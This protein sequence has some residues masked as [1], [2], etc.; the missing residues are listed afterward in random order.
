VAA[1]FHLIRA[2]V[3]RWGLLIALFLA[4]TV[5]QTFLEEQGPILALRN[6]HH[7][8]LVEGSLVFL[9][10]VRL[11][12][13][14]VIIAVVVHDTSIVDRRAFLLT[15]PVTPRQTLLAKFI[16]LGVA[17]VLIPAAIHLARFAQ[18][19]MP[20]DL[21]ALDTIDV[22][23]GWRLVSLLILLL[24]ATLT[25]S[26]FTY[27]VTLVGSAVVLTSGIVLQVALFGP[28]TPPDWLAAG[29]EPVSL[30]T[31]EVTR[32]WL[33]TVATCGIPLVL[34]AR[35]RRD[36]AIA[37]LGVL[38]VLGFI[39]WWPPLP[40]LF[41][42]PVF[43]PPAWA[44]D[45]RTPHLVLDP[46]EASIGA[47]WLGGGVTFTGKVAHRPLTMHG[48][49]FLPDVPRGWVAQVSEL[50]TRF[51]DRNGRVFLG[52]GFVSSGLPRKQGAS[53]Y[54]PF[55]GWRDVLGDQISSA[56]TPLALRRLRSER[57]GLA[58]LEDEAAVAQLTAGPV[59]FDA[60]AVLDLWRFDVAGIVPKAPA[61]IARN[62]T[63][64][65]I[66]ALRQNDRTL[67]VL[68]RRTF[69]S[70]WLRPGNPSR[71]FVVLKAPDAAE[72]DAGGQ[73]GAVGTLPGA[74]SRITMPGW[75]GAFFF[76][77]D[78]LRTEWTLYQFTGWDHVEGG[79]APTPEW[80]E[81]AQFGVVDG[82]YGGR[83]RRQMH[84]E[85]LPVRDQGR[86]PAAAPP[87]ALHPPLH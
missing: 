4:L 28:T 66:V 87:P 40:R 46:V 72:A 39:P 80:I 16:T 62:H 47:P 6:P 49:L 37:A 83:V 67:S 7:G 9:W 27:L 69:L 86:S 19:G 32:T 34:L 20:L 23:L 38:L 25:T 59:R 64:I 35:R 85:A 42:E 36:H 79:T 10:L 18:R 1:V 77:I 33:T 71:V 60:D 55:D 31:F 56:R 68:V 53:A 3:R 78:S 75:H 41:A 73:S 15:R 22:L 52:R 57:V 12:L 74:L 30:D 82:R 24:V 17:F 84:I 48:T 50:R 44:S 45:G 11:L 81:R 61:R 43:T 29:P 8:G 2:D 76:G 54:T 21:V 58:K 51:T 63:L 70:P 65:E 14:A 26:L 5:G 13:T